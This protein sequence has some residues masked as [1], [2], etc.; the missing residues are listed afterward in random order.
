MLTVIRSGLAGH[1]GRSLRNKKIKGQLRTL[2]ALIAKGRSQGFLTYTEINDFLPIASADPERVAEVVQTLGDIGIKVYEAAPAS[3]DVIEPTLHTDEEIV[4]EDTIS[5]LARAQTDTHS[6]L[7]PTRIYM[8]DMGKLELLTREGEVALARQIE[9][10]TREVLSAL[11]YLPGTVDHMLEQYREAD[12]AYR[13]ASVFT[14]YLDPTDV[15]PTAPEFDAHVQQAEDGDDEEE[16]ETPAGPDPEEARRRFAALR[17][18]FNRSQKS[19]ERKGSRSA[20]ALDLEELGEVF[21]RFKFAPKQEEKILRMLKEP[22]EEVRTQ[23]RAIMAS[24]VSG[25]GM[26]R[27]V[28]LSEIRSKGHST[29]WLNRQIRGGYEYS[30]ALAE[31]KAEILRAQRNLDQ[32]SSQTGY[33]IAELKDIN[34]RVALGEAKRLHAKNAMVEANLRLVISISKKYQNRGLPFLDLIQEG[35]TG[36]MKAVDK[37][38]YRRGFKFSTYATWWI[39]QSISRAIADQARTIRVP[40]HMVEAIYKTTWVARQLLQALGREPTPPEIGAR[41]D[42][43]EAQVRRVLRLARQS[44]SL[45]TPIGKDDHASLG[46]HIE[47]ETV[48][49]PIELAMDQ[50]LKTATE[51]VLESLTEREAKILRMRFGIDMSTD[52]TL[53][54]VG[55][56]FGITR[57]RIRQIQEKALRKLRQPNNSEPLRSFLD[58]DDG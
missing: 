44:I 30:A 25:A 47:D 18:A 26:P 57:E 22:M 11:A 6:T 27:D 53:E 42:M 54:E 17:R 2:K 3:E 7:D 46:D 40:V 55:Q 5:T 31:R 49:S 56:Q 21:S 51:S 20:A 35:N 52:H 38:E 10:G 1:G 37:F 19:I 32:I 45:E 8:R 15:V 33:T 13:L 41:L 34:R 39:R 28:F 9:E 43:S 36:L 12:Q 58:D 14:G 29:R 16:K 50:A 48:E 24:C 4:D 23:E